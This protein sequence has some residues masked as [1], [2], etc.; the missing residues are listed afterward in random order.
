MIYT[1]LRVKGMWRVTSI[2]S[3]DKRFQLFAQKG[4][5]LEQK[6]ELLVGVQDTTM[7]VCHEEGDIGVFYPSMDGELVGADDI[8]KKCAYFVNWIVA[9]VQITERYGPLAVVVRFCEKD[10]PVTK[11]CEIVVVAQNRNALG[12]NTCPHNYVGYHPHNF[13]YRILKDL[14]VF[15]AYSSHIDLQEVADYYEYMFT[16]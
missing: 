4:W 12:I 10:K 6:E 7:N 5:S 14:D 16:L 8:M 3:E 1:T 2:D 11:Q 9:S 13:M 15:D